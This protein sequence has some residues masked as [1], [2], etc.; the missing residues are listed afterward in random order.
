MGRFLGF[1]RMT[2]KEEVKF[3]NT[4][5]ADLQFD[6]CTELDPSLTNCGKFA[7]FSTKNI[8]NPIKLCDKLEDAVKVMNNEDSSSV[9]YDFVKNQ[10]D[11]NLE[12][13]L[14]THSNFFDRAA[15]ESIDQFKSSVL[16]A[17]EN[18]LRKYRPDLSKKDALNCCSVE[19]RTWNRVFEDGEIQAD[20]F[21]GL[22]VNEFT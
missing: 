13:F 22:Q 17:C 11:F 18:A 20:E 15:F 9:L 16:S 6:Q 8:N 3:P 2:I 4:K 10:E 12:S 21:E 7:D 5:L 1:F 14:S 19:D